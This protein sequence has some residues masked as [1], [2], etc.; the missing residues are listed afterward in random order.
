MLRKPDD[1]GLQVVRA[2]FEAMGVEEQWSTWEDRGFRWWPSTFQ[3]RVWAEPVRRDQGFQVC[4]IHAV[5]EFLDARTLSDA[6]LAEIAVMNAKS[7]LS[8]VVYDPDTGRVMLHSSVTVHDESAESL[9]RLFALAAGL[10]VGRVHELLVSDVDAR[11]GCARVR[12]HPPGQSQRTEPDEMVGAVR[13][14]AKSAA[15]GLRFSMGELREFIML[16]EESAAPVNA[17]GSILSAE[18][19]CASGVSSVSRFLARA[20]GTNS[21]ETVGT[22]LFRLSLRERHPVLGKGCF[23]ILEAPTVLGDLSPL[24]RAGLQAY[25]QLANLVNLAERDAF[26]RTPSLGAWCASPRGLAYVTFLPQVCAA[27][28]VLGNFY[29]A[30]AMRA[31]WLGGWLKSRAKLLTAMMRAAGPRGE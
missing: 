19:P 16:G 28:G 9:G 7:A 17:S 21:P 12:A 24:S 25:A 1:A 22:A 2:S 11:L 15:P 13:R 10:Q 27:R 29:T 18:F 8:A 4:R 31:Q 30:G 14:T 3:Q 26:V 20:S 5:I 6:A 23:M